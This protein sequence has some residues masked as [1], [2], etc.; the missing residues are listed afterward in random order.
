MIFD[1]SFL[2][3]FSSE[4]LSKVLFLAFESIIGHAFLSLKS[5]KLLHRFQVNGVVKSTE[6]LL[7]VSN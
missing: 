7:V 3:A 2:F 1:F 6:L 5:K 4:A